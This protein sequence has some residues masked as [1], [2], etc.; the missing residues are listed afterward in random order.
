MSEAGTYTVKFERIGR[1][2]NIAPL[3]TDAADL[4]DLAEKI[5]RYARPH[6]LSRDYA[7]ELNCVDGDG[8]GFIACGFHCAGDF[9]I[10]VTPSPDTATENET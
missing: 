9:S 7:V 10:S 3:V 6:V 4:N 5:H 2:H 1:N 8:E